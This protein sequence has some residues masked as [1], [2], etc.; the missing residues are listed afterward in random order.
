MGG[1]RFMLDRDYSLEPSLLFKT[2]EQINYQAD[3]ACRLYYRN[4]YWG[5][6]AFRTG[7][8]LIATAGM[9]YDRFYFGYSCDIIFN[10]I[11]SYSYGSHELMVAYKFGMNIRQY[12]WLERY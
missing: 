9:R 2:T 7:G 5:G 6:L 12:K 10:K 3:I 8:W 11:Q 4:M 1:Y